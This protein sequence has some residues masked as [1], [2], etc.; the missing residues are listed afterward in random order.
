LDGQ[1]GQGGELTP[2][3]SINNMIK[4]LNFHSNESMI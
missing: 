2:S 1:E 4:T 3:E